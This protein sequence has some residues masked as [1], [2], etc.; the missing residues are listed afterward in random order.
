MLPFS[1][2]AHTLSLSPHPTPVSERVT[3]V[4]VPISEEKECESCGCSYMSEGP[5]EGPGF[6]LCPECTGLFGIWKERQGRGR[7]S[8]SLS[9]HPTQE[10]TPTTPLPSSSSSSSRSSPS[11]E[12]PSPSTKGRKRSGGS[13]TPEVPVSPRHVQGDQGK[14]DRNFKN[15]G[16][17]RRK[18]HSCRQLCQGTAFIGALRLCQ[19]CAPLYRPGRVMRRPSVP[20]SPSP[21]SSSFSSPSPISSIPGSKEDKPLGDSSTALST[22]WRPPQ[23]PLTS[24][25]SSL[26]RLELAPLYYVHPSLSK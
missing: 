22:G 24:R 2:P 21:S 1:Y 5:A 19:E 23:G 10:I 26:A 6:E 14:M 9:T 16:G 8:T 4:I 13:K 3:K 15:L 7:R 12:P 11:L 20:V 25:A 18:C 17:L